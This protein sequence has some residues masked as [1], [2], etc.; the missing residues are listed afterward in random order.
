MFVGKMWALRA[1]SLMVV[2]LLA[3]A[4]VPSFASFGGPGAGEDTEGGFAPPGDL[5]DEQLQELLSQQGLGDG[6][7]GGGMDFG[8][9]DFA[10]MMKNM[11]GDMMGM[12]SLGGM[13]DIAMMRD[14]E[15]TTGDIKFILCDTCENLV[16]NAW[17]QIAA[18]RAKFPKTKISEDRIDDALEKICNSKEEPGLWIGRMDMVEDGDRIHLE[19]KGVV[20]RCMVECK[21]IEAACSKVNEEINTDLVEA[22]YM[23]K[24]DLQTLKNRFCSKQIRRMK[25]ACGKPYPPVPASREAGGENFYPKTEEELGMDEI[26]RKIRASPQGNFGVREL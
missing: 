23:G 16:E 6:G 17:N 4:V 13:G 2:L 8:D 14:T 26:N 15:P 20:G 11:G 25:G 5:T 19:D 9:M 1:K 24:S 7:E 22:L 3:A 12:E 18:L 10:E 21:T